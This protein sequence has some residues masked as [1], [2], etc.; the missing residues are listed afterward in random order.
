[1]SKFIFDLAGIKTSIDAGQSKVFEVS[2]PPNMTRE[3][4]FAIFQKQASAGGLTGFQSGDILSALTQAADGLAEAQAELTQGFAGFPGTDQGVQNQLVSI[5]QSAKQSLAA[6]NT[7]NLQSRITN[8]GTIL[9]QTSAK[10]GALFGVPVTN[11][12]D[13][14]DF[15]KTATAIMPMAG[16]NTTDVRATM[17]SVG[18]ATGQ[19]FDQITNAIGVGKFGFDATQLETAGLL[20][21]GTASTFLKQGI[22]NLTSVLKS[23]AVWTGADGITGLDSFLSN[24]SV[25]NLTQQNL[26]S[27]G[28]ATASALGVPL[29]V[30]NAK[31]LG[32][33]ASVFAENSAASTGFEDSCRQ[34]SRLNLMPS[35]KKHNLQ[36]VQQSKNSMM[37]CYNRH[38][39]EKHL[40][41]LTGSLLMLHLTESWATTKFLISIMAVK[42]YH[43]YQHDHIHW[44]QHYQSK[45]KVH[46]H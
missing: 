16:L 32:G 5:A 23:S 40:T 2:G 18:A 28:L 33:I 45:Q 14:A 4:A 8:V 34:T 20:K 43:K 42:L 7:G 30:F 38:H 31:E 19:N 13:V 15:A 44:L 1:M 35:L 29:D 10:I 27:S 6:G 25:Q 11:G 12:I 39:Q 36:L 3:Q 21:P 9:Q 17:A 24:P 41:Q 37:L 22:N 26:M 46:T